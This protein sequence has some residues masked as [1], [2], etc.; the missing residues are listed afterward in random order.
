MV[1]EIFFATNTLK[2]KISPNCIANPEDN[3]QQTFHLLV[4][5]DKFKINLYPKNLLVNLRYLIIK[6]IQKL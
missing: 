6:V 1:S 2:H 3:R 4:E 5:I